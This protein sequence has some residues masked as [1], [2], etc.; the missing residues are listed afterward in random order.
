M[1]PNEASVLDIVAN[2]K[3]I[4]I[5][6]LTE[7]ERDSHLA[8]DDPAT[9]PP[10]GVQNAALEAG[11]LIFN[12]SAN[13]FQYWDGVRWQQFYYNPISKEGNEGVVRID[14]SSVYG[15]LHRQAFTLN[16]SS[17]NFGPAVTLSYS[18]PLVLAPSPTTSWPENILNPQDSDIYYQG[19]NGWRL[20]ENTVP[21]QVHVWRLIVEVNGTSGSSGSM[22]AVLRN[23]D[24][25]FSVNAISLIPGG[26]NHLPNKLTFYFYTIADEYSLSENRGYEIL[27]SA[28][29]DVQVRI[30]S[31]TRISMSK[32]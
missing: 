19:A 21:G 4:L 30:E 14:G 8:D 27:L 17:N 28:T 29:R 18:Y 25:G 26:I 11:T 15:N 12:S 10:V 31:L 6:R 13:A 3:G 24:S 23:P 1:T 22:M 20:K 9:I 32:D 2:D 16:H 7:Q 5:P